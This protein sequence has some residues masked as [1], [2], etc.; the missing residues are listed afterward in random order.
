MNRN[1]IRALRLAVVW[2]ASTLAGICSSTAAQTQEQL[3]AG[4]KQDDEIVF[5][6]GAQTFGGKKS[7]AGLE[8][9]FNIIIGRGLDANS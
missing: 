7:L 2:F 5:V 4:A 3:I 1:G 6:A 8:A 9:A